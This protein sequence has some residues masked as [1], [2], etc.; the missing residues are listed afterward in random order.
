M[1]MDKF[2]ELYCAVESVNEDNYYV[3]KMSAD[4]SSKLKKAAAIAGVGVLVSGIVGLVATDS[5]RTE[6]GYNKNPEMKVLRDQI[7][8]REKELKKAVTNLEQQTKRV[9]AIAQSYN[10]IANQIG[11]VT[12]TLEENSNAGL[13]IKEENKIGF[14]RGK[15]SEK[16]NPNYSTK[17]YMDA[18]KKREI[19]NMEVEKYNVLVKEVNDIYKDLQKLLKKFNSAVKML[20]VSPKVQAKLTEELSKIEERYSDALTDINERNAQF[21]K[22]VRESEEDTNAKL[23]VHESYRCGDITEEERD[24]LL[25]LMD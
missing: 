25:D 10:T 3:E 19:L 16:E 7:L 22:F 1:N 20:K 23:F 11:K 15:S 17:I 6:Y 18:S 21:S 14:I 2:T 13:S 12:I 8:K 5:K 24:I 9:E 4:A